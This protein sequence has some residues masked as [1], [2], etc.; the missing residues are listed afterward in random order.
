MQNQLQKAQNG[1]FLNS[2]Q[3]QQYVTLSQQYLDAS[4]KRA[5]EEKESLG[6]VVK[7]YGLN[8]ENV[9][10]IEAP[11]VAALPAAAP[12]AGATQRNVKVDY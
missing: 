5:N 7:N 8:P 6:K 1:Q 10:G 2:K 9:F 4:K 11:P 12:A 3:R